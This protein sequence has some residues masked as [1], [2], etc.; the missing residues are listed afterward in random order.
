MD[1]TV[2]CFFG[3]PKTE[4]VKKEPSTRDLHEGFDITLTKHRGQVDF[5]PRNLIH[6]TNFLCGDLSKLDL[7]VPCSMLYENCTMKVQGLYAYSIQHPHV[8]HVG[9]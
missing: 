7:F 5:F 1:L 8:V 4:E 6:A 3:Q 9:H 2:A